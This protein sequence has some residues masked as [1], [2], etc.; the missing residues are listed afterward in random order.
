MQGL[1]LLEL[2]PRTTSSIGTTFLSLKG[3]DSRNM[4][5]MNSS[6]KLDIKKFSSKAT[7]SMDRVMLGVP[8]MPYVNRFSTLEH[9]RKRPSI[10][11]VHTKAIDY[12][13]PT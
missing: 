12:T 6:P 10:H 7:L 9:V 2:A 4:A 3:G 11:E 8:P 13:R 5:S 1:P